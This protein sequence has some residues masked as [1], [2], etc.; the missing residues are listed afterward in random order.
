MRQ[1]LCEQL[2]VGDDI[3]DLGADFGID[4][5]PRFGRLLPVH[6]DFAGH[7]ERLCLLA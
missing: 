1:N 5:L 2:V 7:D 3:I 4:G 6:P